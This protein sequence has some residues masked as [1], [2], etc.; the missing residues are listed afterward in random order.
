MKIIEY[1]QG[2]V[3]VSLV[4]WFQE[5]WFKEPHVWVSKKELGDRHCQGGKKWLFL[6]FGLGD[7]FKWFGDGVFMS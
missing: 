7:E 1:Q 4:V 6:A 2:G 3:G 5:C